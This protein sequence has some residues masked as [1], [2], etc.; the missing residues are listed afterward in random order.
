M[1]G[2]A[3][4]AIC[5]IGLG[6]SRS[7]SLSLV[8]RIIYGLLSGNTPVCKSLIRELTDNKNISKLY[9][10]YGLGAGLSN[11]L[12]PL[13]VALSNP[14]FNFGGIFKTPFF[15]TYPYFLPFIMQ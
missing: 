8:I 6:L 10:Y 7:F 13:F 5:S 9:K 12:G 3:S 14:A 15:Y 11:I 1:I 2:L 4:S